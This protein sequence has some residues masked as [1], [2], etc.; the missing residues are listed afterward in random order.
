MNNIEIS[1]LSKSEWEK[2]RKNYYVESKNHDPN[3]RKDLLF[4]TQD[5]MDSIPMYFWLTNGT[6]LGFH[7]DGDFIPWDDDIDIDALGPEMFSNFDLLSYKYF[8]NNMSAINIANLPN[9][10]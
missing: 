5:V 3:L 1:N 7:R 8:I 9:F 2:I 10:L 6:A 4:E